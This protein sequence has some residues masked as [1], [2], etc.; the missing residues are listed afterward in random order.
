MEAEC[1]DG[2]RREARN[3]SGRWWVR[4]LVGL[5]SVGAGAVGEEGWIRI[6]LGGVLGESAMGWRCGGRRAGDGPT[7]E[8]W[9][10]VEDVEAVGPSLC[11]RSVSNVRRLDGWGTML[12]GDTRTTSHR[13]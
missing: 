1:E 7:E 11:G 9:A 3:W 10:E 13:A 12:E 2:C 5:C 8:G 4:G 6:G